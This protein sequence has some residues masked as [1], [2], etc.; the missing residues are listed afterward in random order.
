MTR[1]CV[2]FRQASTP[3]RR[4]PASPSGSS[5]REIAPSRPVLCEVSSVLFKHDSVLLSI[6]RSIVPGTTPGPNDVPSSADGRSNRL[7]SGT[8]FVRLRLRIGAASPSEAF[9]GCEACFANSFS[10]FLKLSR[11]SSEMMLAKRSE[12]CCI[13]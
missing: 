7:I 10:S 12:P 13:C 11:G 1:R 3:A 8:V 2:Y 9:A 4:R 6:Y 5:E